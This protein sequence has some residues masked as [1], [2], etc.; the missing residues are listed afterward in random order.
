[1]HSAIPLFVRYEAWTNVFYV[2]FGAWWLS[3]MWILSR[4]RRAAKGVSGDRGSY[5]VIMILLPLAIASAFA[6]PH[7]CPWAAIGGPGVVWLVAAVALMW[8]GIAF[9]LWAVLTLGR[10]F[11]TSVLV[12]DDHELITRGPYR[13]LRHPSYT[14]TFVTVLGF[15]LA[16]GN[17]MSI[18]IALAL[19]M[20]AFGRRMAVEDQALAE[21]FGEAY[22]ARRR[23][24]WAVIPYIW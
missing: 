20:I 13:R 16:I 3:E 11:R 9:R 22:A 8:G 5:G 21:K 14:G 7:Y 2:S 18:V 10:Y 1:M 4:D 19:T 17:W 15:G 6:A 23:N 12:H 24:T